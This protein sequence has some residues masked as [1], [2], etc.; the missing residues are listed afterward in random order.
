M[1]K[2]Q[3]KKLAAYSSLSSAFLL[4]SN[5]AN[6]QVVYTDV[7]PDGI[8][9]ADDYLLDIDNDGVVD[10]KLIFIVDASTSYALSEL[11]LRINPLGSNRMA[12]SIQN[13][14]V[15]YSGMPSS[16]YTGGATQIPFTVAPVLNEGAIINAGLNFNSDIVNLYERLNFNVYSNYNPQAITGGSWQGAEN[17]FAAFQFYIDGALHYGWMRLS[18][19]ILTGITLHDFAYELNPLTPITT[20]IVEYTTTWNY[21]IDGGTIG[22]AEDLQY[23]F[24]A[25]GDE[26]DI[27]NYRV[28]CVKKENANAFN[29]DLANALPADEYLEIMPDGSAE[30]SGAFSALSRD[31][32]G[33]II[34]LGQEYKLFILNVM[35]PPVGYENILSQASDVVQLIDIVSPATDVFVTDVFD[36]GN[37]SD[38]KV[39]FSEPAINQGISEYRIMLVQKDLA[40]VFTLDDANLIAAGNYTPVET[41]SVSYIINLNA[42]TK[43]VDGNLIEPEKYKCFVLSVSDGTSTNQSALSIPSSATTIETI[44]S[45][46]QN[47]LFEDIAETGNGNDVKISFDAPVYEQ[48]IVEYRIILVDF[49]TAFD[50]D[51]DAALAVPASR[52]ITVIPNDNPITI[53]GNTNTKDSEGNLIVWGVPYFAYV[54][55][56]PSTYGIGDTLSQ[57]SNQLIINFP[58]VESISE[59]TIEGVNIFNE[60]HLIH[61]NL[62]AQIQNKTQFYLYSS[63]GQLCFSSEIKQ[64]E[65]VFSVDVAGGIYVAV[66]QSGDKRAIKK[67]VIN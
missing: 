25:A 19:D 49:I 58:V 16:T 10:F 4:L 20:Q 34:T 13:V 17:K 14:P 42:L 61:I 54:L 12:F 11:K 28:I 64:A 44:T 48:T 41:D 56:T 24:T 50:F 3:I 65:N 55:S 15:T 51:L 23:S 38:L 46:A 62:N 31:S 63:I 6:A 53:F 21:A 67:L 8:G 26:V 5:A 30:Y 66:L 45:A 29:I 18:V 47:I 22:N 2:E 7:I 37:G 36:T 57:P 60:N 27:N 43:D 59:N 33:D 32:D 35:E 39:Q 52:Y 1:K 9:F 40:D